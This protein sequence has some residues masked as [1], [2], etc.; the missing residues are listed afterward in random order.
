M[1]EL[2]ELG[3]LLFD[4]VHTCLVEGTLEEEGASLAQSIYSWRKSDLSVLVEPEHIVV[5]GFLLQS[6]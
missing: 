1:E 2:W 3:S 5:Q 6:I 4:G